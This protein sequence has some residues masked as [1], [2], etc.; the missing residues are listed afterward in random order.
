MKHGAPG[1]SGPARLATAAGLAI[2]L[3]VAVWTPAAW[4]A[5][6]AFEVSA[7][8]ANAP[9]GTS[10]TVTVTRDA[11]VNP[12]SV[13]LRTVD[14]TAT[15]GQD[16]EPVDRRVE[17]TSET[18]QQL[19]LQILQ[20]GADE[21]A[22][23][24]RLE[25]SE[26]AGC[27]VNP[28]FRYDSAMVTVADDDDPSPAPSPTT[29]PPAPGPTA[30]PPPGATTTAAAE[31][32]STT[33]AESTTT[34]DSDPSATTGVPPTVDDASE[35]ALGDDDGGGGGLG[36]VLVAVLLAGAGGAGGYL[37]YRRSR[38]A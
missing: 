16:Y 13:R 25:L 14:G 24:F 38:P 19:T 36:W 8:P 20:D 30:A 23:T 3:L 7:D 5:C 4:A 21:P 6:H 33:A 2:T 1:S 11:A 15:G 31:S 9:E 22:E 29:A 34:T 28:S 10:V 27:E 35:D 26:G 32:T 18:Q 37:L 12:S 17:F